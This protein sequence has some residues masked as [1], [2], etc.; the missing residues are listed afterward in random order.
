VR[1]G[2]TQGWKGR[3]CDGDLKCLSFWFNCGLCVVFIIV[4]EKNINRLG[5]RCVC[6]GGIDAAQIATTDITHN[7]LHLT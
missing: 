2:D 3:N 5:R 4:A 7:A 1:I 6:R